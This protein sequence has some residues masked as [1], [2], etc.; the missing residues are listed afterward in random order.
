M[1]NRVFT[2]ISAVFTLISLAA[3]GGT[4]AVFVVVYHFSSD[5]P[6]FDQLKNYNPPT[7]TRVYSIDGQ[8][9]AE[10]AKEKRLYVPIN[11][12]PN[13]VKNAFIAAEDKNFYSHP[14]IDFI[15][16]LRAGTHNLMY[17]GHNKSLVGGSTITQQVVKNFLLTSEKSISRKIK[18]AILAFRITQAFSK[19][20]ILELYLNQIYLGNK[21]YGVAAAALNYFNKSVDELAIEE[22]AMLASLP[23]APS[24]LDP[25]RHPEP[26]K[27]RRDW[28]I[29]RM[30][31]DGY[32]TRQDAEDA[33]K[34]PINLRQRD[35]VELVNAQFYTD[36]VKRQLIE[37]FGEDKVME[38][39]L[40]VHTNL[41]PKMQR[42][43]E[44]GLIDGLIAYDRRHGWRGA[45]TNFADLDGWAEKLKKVNQP[46]IKDW[47]LAVVLNIA[48]DNSV[49]IGFSNS[50]NG[51]IL[52]EDIRWARKYLNE[53]SLGAS[54]RK[55]TDVVKK[56]DVIFVSPKINPKDN[57]P[58]KNLFTLEQ[59]PAVNGSIVVMDPHTGRVLAIVGGF[60]Y[61]DSQ[62]N[63]AIQA[64]RQPGSSFKPFVY[65]AALENGFAPNTII[66]DE[67]VE[68]SQG[69][70][71]PV[72]RPQNHTKDFLG[73]VPMRVGIEKSRNT[74]TVRLAQM[75]G[76]DRIIEIAKRFNVTADPVRNFSVA[77]GT[78][79]VTLLD[80]T[81]SYCMLVNGGRYVT[82]G[83]I[84]WV[85]DKNGK[86]VYRR[87]KRKCDK[88]LTHN[89][90][91]VNV[92]DADKT[93]PDLPDD[94]KV[95]ADQVN[96]YQM[97][98]MLEGVVQRG[99]ARAAASLGRTLAGKTGTTND[100][101]DAWFIGFSADLT[102]GVFVGFDNP[103]SLGH[104]EYGSTAALPVWENFMKQAL[105]GKPDVPFRR[106]PGVK[107]VR[108]DAK[109]GL[110]PT[111]SSTSIILEA[112]KAGTEP[113]SSTSG[114]NL[115]I[116]NQPPDPTGAGSPAPSTAP[117]GNGGVY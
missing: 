92:P 4:V 20:K 5:L 62:F 19:D 60:Y 14:G 9:L 38:E 53:N 78:S 99:T 37:M 95:I 106:P 67:A 32:I 7:V 30:S 50:G 42:M 43:A 83:L 82:P 36:A 80:I 64:K 90:T 79:E 66:V 110:L 39:G 111:S 3:I 17:M 76:I 96:T 27:D 61:A 2:L 59:L 13:R 54:V 81:N 46:T 26:A 117:I 44:D 112:F 40:A 56:G 98:S 102:A 71:L 34:R 86:I 21:S 55:A 15:S 12:I 97:V 57:K 113:T 23:K 11:A 74:M 31:E 116:G 49:H 22:A 91:L 85:E 89:P 47:R 69:S 101:F 103:K 70:S 105:A 65:L 24:S 94:R 29:D 87:D 8:M 10:Y 41:D 114:G 109:T 72:W 18:E 108:I 107:L 35:S 58:V 33:K 28:V 68:L 52:L 100:S 84:E 75:I 1:V 73:P 104:H 88:C 93:L 51:K 77:L 16:I 48:D 45:V 115:P 25:W 63:R 6:G